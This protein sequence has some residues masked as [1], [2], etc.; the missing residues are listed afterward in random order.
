MENVGLSLS[1]P[2]PRRS[3]MDGQARPLIR[4]RFSRFAIQPRVSPQVV[5]QHDAVAG[6]AGAEVIESFIDLREGEEL[7]GG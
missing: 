4:H 3:A 5:D 2:S 6:F 7:R 1:W